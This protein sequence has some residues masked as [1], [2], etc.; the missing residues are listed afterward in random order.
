MLNPLCY[1][2]QFWVQLGLQRRKSLESSFPWK[3]S[4]FV[5]T[6][7]IWLSHTIFFFSTL[8]SSSTLTISWILSMQHIWRT[9]HY[10]W[11]LFGNL[12]ILQTKASSHWHWSSCFSIVG[13]SNYIST[14][15]P[16]F[17]SSFLNTKDHWLGSAVDIHIEVTT[18]SSFFPALVRKH[19]ETLLSQLLL[20]LIYTRTAC[21]ISM[22][23]L[24][25]RNIL[26]DIVLNMFFFN[27]IVPK[28]TS[29]EIY[30]CNIIYQVP[31][32]FVQI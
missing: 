13:S 3:I 20:L 24:Y 1:A 15:T 18:L 28:E 5:Y 4:I 12:G 22:I 32:P 25:L 14:R 6:S 30:I 17:S 26:K 19:T 21:W 2:S 31:N 11:A 27:N 8:L 23:H 7:H 10:I 16:F 9:S 29:F